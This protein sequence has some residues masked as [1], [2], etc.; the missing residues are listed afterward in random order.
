[1]SNQED[2]NEKLRKSLAL[3]DFASGCF[4]KGNPDTHVVGDP[5]KPD[6]MKFILT[7]IDG[8][9]RTF[10][11]LDVPTLLWRDEF[12]Q[13]ASVN[14]THTRIRELWRREFGTELRQL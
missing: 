9:V 8:E 10:P 5:H 14:R 12:L 11:L 13:V 2:L 4:I 3:M 7:L 1:M 6:S